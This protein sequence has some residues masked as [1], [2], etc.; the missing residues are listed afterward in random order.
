VLSATQI[1]AELGEMLNEETS[2]K[3]FLVRQSALNNSYNLILVI[4][5]DIRN[6]TNSFCKNVLKTITS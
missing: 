3:P 5:E 4:C 6:G 2:I 1:Y